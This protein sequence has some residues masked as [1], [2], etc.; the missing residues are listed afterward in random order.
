[1]VNREMA[2]EERE[3]LVLLPEVSP[4]TAERRVVGRVMVAVG[5]PVG[6]AVE[7]AMAAA[8][9]LPGVERGT[10]A[11]VELPAVERMTVA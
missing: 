8:V 3:T 5:L 10:E 9:A 7:R 2:D 4:G 1:M 11:A 6:A